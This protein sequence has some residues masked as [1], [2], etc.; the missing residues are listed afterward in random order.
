MTLDLTDD[1]KRALARLLRRAI[2]DDRYP[3][4]PRL[5]PLEGDPGEAKSAA[6]AVRTTAAVAG[7]R[8]TI[9]GRQMAAPRGMKPY[10]GPPMT[11]PE[12]DFACGAGLQKRSCCPQPMGY[13]GRR[14][15]T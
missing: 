11:V 4:S 12:R 3:V 14:C 13:E 9:C 7:A 5:A 2:D 8:R 1:E 6:T 10:R 15:R